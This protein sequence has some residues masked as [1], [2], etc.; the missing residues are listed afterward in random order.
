MERQRARNLFALSD[1][2]GATLHGQLCVEQSTKAV[3]ACF[4]NPEHE[5]DCSRALFTVLAEHAAE[6]RERHGEDVL[7]RLRRLGIDTN[8]IADWH[9]RA[10]YGEDLPDGT[11]VS[12]ADLVT[13]C[14]AQWAVALAERSCPTAREFVEAWVAAGTQG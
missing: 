1:Y 4:E 8:S 7:T 11:H 2:P 14:D 12:A 3:I 10:T 9:E 5:H 6:I 13:E